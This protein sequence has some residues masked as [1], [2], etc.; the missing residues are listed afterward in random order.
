MTGKWGT[1]NMKGTEQ[2]SARLI[3][4][5]MNYVDG[6]YMNDGETKDFCETYLDKDH[7]G[8]EGQNVHYQGYKCDG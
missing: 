3:C 6:E 1:V 7:C 2:S 8:F 4:K 5:A